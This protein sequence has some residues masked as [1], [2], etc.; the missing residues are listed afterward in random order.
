VIWRFILIIVLNHKKGKRQE[1]V[2]V[3]NGSFVV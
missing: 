1:V 3:D 2:I